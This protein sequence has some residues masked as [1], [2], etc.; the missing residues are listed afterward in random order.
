MTNIDLTRRQL[1]QRTGI[2]A[3][4]TVALPAWVH[5]AAEPANEA[6]SELVPQSVIANN[7]GHALSLTLSELILNLRRARAE[8]STRLGIQGR[9]GHPHV[10]TLRET[11]LVLLLIDGELKV[12][13]SQDAGHAHEVTLSLKAQ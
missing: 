5:A 4:S 11:D 9:S 7:H 10:L 13:S 8:G 2:L 1:L 3:I 6:A 12:T